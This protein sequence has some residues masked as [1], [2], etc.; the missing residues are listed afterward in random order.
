MSHVWTGR[1]SGSGDGNGR[2]R[3]TGKCPTIKVLAQGIETQFL[4]DTGSMV[5][6]LTETYFKQHLQ[7][8]LN[9]PL[10]HCD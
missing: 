8:L 6:T 3:L 7:P 1:S 4:L 9:Q 2:P 10:H 5:T